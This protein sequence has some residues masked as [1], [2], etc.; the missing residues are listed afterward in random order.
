[1]IATITYRQMSNI[2]TLGILL[3]FVPRLL[4]GEGGKRAWYTLFAHAP[5]S[6][7]NLRYTKITVKSVYLLK[8]LHCKV[9]C[10]LPAKHIMGG[11]EVRIKQYSFDIK[12]VHCFILGGR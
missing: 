3:S 4:C 9:T 10:I 6:L 8:R 1:M 2:F 11:F 12:S 5:S 7:G